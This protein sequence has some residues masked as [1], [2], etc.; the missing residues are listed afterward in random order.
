MELAA[1]KSLKTVGLRGTPVTASGVA[2]LAKVRP[3][4]T[5][6]SLG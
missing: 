1:F 2:A 6:S 4:L 5:F 3:T